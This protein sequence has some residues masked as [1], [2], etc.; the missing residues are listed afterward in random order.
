MKLLQKTSELCPTV[1]FMTLRRNHSSHQWITLS[2][3]HPTLSIHRFIIWIKV[4]GQVVFMRFFS[5]GSGI[6]TIMTTFRIWDTYHC[7]SLY[8]FVWFHLLYLLQNASDGFDLVSLNTDFLNLFL[9]EIDYYD[10][11]CSKCLKYLSCTRW[12]VCGRPQR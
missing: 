10:F 11:K 6:K 12:F 7:I 1:V 9:L 4:Y 3:A 5:N 8:W 2:P